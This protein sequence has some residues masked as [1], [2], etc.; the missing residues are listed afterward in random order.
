MAKGDKSSSDSQ[1][2]QDYGEV[3]YTFD[4]PEFVPQERGMTW[5]LVM[6][7]CVLCGVL[8][9]IIQGSL[10]LV[11][12]SVAIGAVYTLSNGKTPGEYTV[13][14]TKL[15]VEWKNQFYLYQDTETFWIVWEGGKNKTLHI[16]VSKGLVRELVIPIY[17]QPMDK[18]RNTLG[19]YVPET[20]NRDEGWS[21]SL[22][23]KMKL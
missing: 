20:E 21:R 11:L 3:I 13:K 2:L 6:G 5:F 15:G 1:K 4:A 14:F 7:L 17:R 10:S 19:F 22:A 16:S 8:L 23:R 9:G 18:I 12:V